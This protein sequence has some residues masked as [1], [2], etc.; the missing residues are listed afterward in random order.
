MNKCLVTTLKAHTNNEA[1][2]KYNVLTI[3]T[4]VSDA[5]TVDTQWL[6]IGA[7]DNGSV[8]INSS[9]VGLYKSGIS[10]E[11]LSYPYNITANSEISTH[12]ENKDGIIEV[13]NKYNINSL[14][15]GKNSILRIKE[16]YGIP[17]T[18]KML[19]MFNIEEKEIDAT[20]L[21]KTLDLDNLKVLSLSN[22]VSIDIINRVNKNIIGKFKA[23]SLVNNLLCSLF[24]SIG[25]DD[26]ANNINIATINSTVLKAG[27][28]SSLAKLINVTT[29]SFKDNVQ[30][31]GDIMDF[32]NPWIQAGRTSGKINVQWLLGQ[33]NIT[34]NGRPI[35]YPSG[36]S[37]VSAYLNWTSDGTVTF[38]AS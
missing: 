25:L 24:D 13:T 19:N 34:L 37:N 26:L 21:I 6:Q 11:L 1:L 23:I 32:I 22:M 15:S 16:I 14:I 30:N 5:P 12:F 17:G 29:I 8:S 38:T 28:L 3:K 4:K 33:K 35:S 20:R 7:S 36:V 27:N 31:N 9:N 18:I 10:G 2:S